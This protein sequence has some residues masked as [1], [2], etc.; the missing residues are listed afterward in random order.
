MKLLDTNKNVIESKKAFIYKI[1]GKEYLFYTIGEPVN[2]LTTIGFGELKNNELVAVDP[3]D[4]KNVSDFISAFA[5]NQAGGN[6]NYV[7]ENDRLIDVTIN[8]GSKT[9]IP[10]NVVD[11]LV[12]PEIQLE[13]KQVQEKDKYVKPI[14]SATAQT[15]TA[16][17]VVKQEQNVAEQKESAFQ[18]SLNN[19]TPEQVKPKKRKKGLIIFFAILIILGVLGYFGFQFITSPKVVAITSINNLTKG[20]NETF[21][22]KTVQNLNKFLYNTDKIKAKEDLSLNIDSK[23]GLST[24]TYTFSGTYVEN[25]SSKASSIDANLTGGDNKIISGNAILSN[26]K[27]Y[28][29]INDVL[30]KYYY[31][32]QDYYSIF[33]KVDTSNMDVFRKLLVQS[34][35]SNIKNEDFKV[36]NEQITL[37]SSVKVKKYSLELTTAKM[38]TILKDYFDRIQNDGDAMNILMTTNSMTKD[39]VVQKLSDTLKEYQNKY[40]FTTTLNMYVKDINTVVLFELIGDKEIIDYYQ[41]DSTKEIRIIDSNTK[42][43]LASVKWV[44]SDN[45][46]NVTIKYGDKTYVTGTV[47]KDGTY[48]LIYT[49]NDNAN[50]ELKGTYELK[51]IS[52]NADYKVTIELTAILSGTS[53][54]TTTSYTFNIKNQ[55]E[56]TKGD[57]VD[58]IA[59]KDAANI[60][61]ITPEDQEKLYSLG[62][63]FTDLLSKY[64]STESMWK[65]VSIDT[66]FFNS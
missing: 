9:Q 34:L 5:N 44:L 6:I 66:S 40:N 39:E 8:G 19:N 11:S 27:L 15:I 47:G 10:S 62:S 57:N 56:F 1:F 13:Q 3:N 30:S 64:D 61:D 4:L 14:I 25:A 22:S 41:Y 50:I 2:N 63:I 35:G 60:K 54:G 18:A 51:E 46:Y 16:E 28:F 43:A 12:V 29:T 7:L 32:D 55:L 21:N 24:N 65:E 33:N 38:A 59:T 45:T 48:D 23:L 42:K 53:N 49:I 52:A 17:S 31:Q 20:L 26:N 37:D 36:T 58:T